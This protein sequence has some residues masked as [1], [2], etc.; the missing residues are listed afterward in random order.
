MATSDDFVRA[1]ARA[2]IQVIR[3]Y[4]LDGGSAVTIWRDVEAFAHG[5][6]A[7]ATDLRAIG[8]KHAGAAAAAFCGGVK[9]RAP[10]AALY[11]AFSAFARASH[12]YRFLDASR[13]I[14]LYF[15]FVDKRAIAETALQNEVLE[16]LE[17]ALTV[18]LARNCGEV[19]FSKATEADGWSIL[20]A[21]ESCSDDEGRCASGTARREKW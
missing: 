11:L 21:N 18:E 9:L 1:Q 8:R 16:R 15:A 19:A 12:S 2:L 20:A 10:N 5:G 4:N 3:Y 14:A 6:R 13:W 7:Q 17:T